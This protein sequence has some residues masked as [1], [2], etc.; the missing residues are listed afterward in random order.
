VDISNVPLFDGLSGRERE[1]ALACFRPERIPHGTPVVHEGDQGSTLVVLVEGELEIRTGDLE[2]STIR[3]GEMIG[4]NGLFTRG[5]RTATVETNTECLVLKLSPDGYAEL[6]RRSNPVATRIERQALASLL[7][8]LRAIDDR[9]A[10]LAHGTAIAHHKPSI[11]FF[12]RVSRLF[13]PG[14]SKSVPKVDP[15]TVLGA[16]PL[17]AGV[18]SEDL[19]EVAALFKVQAWAGGEFLCTEGEAGDS[20]YV[21]AQGVV[22][23]LVETESDRVEPVATLGTGDAFGMAGVVDQRPRTAS[24]VTRGDTVVLCL[25]RSAWDAVVTSENAASRALRV[26]MIRALAESLAQANG[27]LAL[28]DLTSQDDLSALVMASALVEA[29][30]RKSGD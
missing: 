20:L 1:Q 29:L 10:Q 13:G 17:F 14:G 15:V 2:L 7:Q 26:A 16:S 19:A 24:C 6:I 30:P 18:A 23:V 9:I 12:E 8:R 21:I 22:D 27:H 28:L 4:E 3:S 11:T 25:D 5:V